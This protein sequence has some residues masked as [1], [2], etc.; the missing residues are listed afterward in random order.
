M[1]LVRL[2]EAEERENIPSECD[3]SMEFR[4]ENIAYVCKMRCVQKLQVEFRQAER[5]YVI[6]TVSYAQAAIEAS[7]ASKRVTVLAE[8]WCVVVR[9]ASCS[10]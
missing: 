8:Q 6:Y 7:Q 2:V 3:T 4:G 9:S 5:E 1:Q 10:S